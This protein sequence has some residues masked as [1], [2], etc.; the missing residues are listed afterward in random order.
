LRVAVVGGGIAGLAAAW[1]LATTKQGAQ[2]TVF[3]PDRLGGKILTAGFA[4]RAV[5][6]GPDAFIARVP[7]AVELCRE[8]GLESELV[9]PAATRALLWTRGRLRPLPEGLV[10]GVPAKLGGLLTAGILSPLGVARAALDV[11]L[12][13]TRWPEDMAVADVVRARFGRQVA[14]RLVD[15][16]LGGI[17]AGSTEDLSV[18]ATAP[19]LARAARTSRSLLL[20]L[21]RAGSPAAGGPMFLAPARGMGRLVDAMVAALAERG[22]AFAREMVAD[23]TGEKGGRLRVEPAGVF[24]AVIVATPAAAAAKLLAAA[25]PAAAGQLAGIRSASVVL[26]TFAYN[27]VVPDGASGFLVPRH[28]GRLMTACSFGS[29]KWPQWANPGQVVLRVSAGRAGDDRPFQ[30]DDETVVERLQ[31]ELAQALGWPAGPTAWRVSRWPEAFPQYEVGHLALV[32]RVEAEL[33]RS[34]PAVALAGAGYRGSGIPACIASG[35]RAAVA[36]MS[37]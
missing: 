25:C 27:A 6:T 11:G 24:D 10:V 13:A 22:V 2:V 32:A 35:R 8:L 12:P 34:L 19:Q 7:D 33:R 3:E 36:V 16:L 17:H 9:A 15:P 14:E 21:R 31:A 18:E 28:E 4:G 5:D 37:R 20:G 23:I 1:Q 26:V 30:L 29:S